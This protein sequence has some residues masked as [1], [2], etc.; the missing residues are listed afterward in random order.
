MSIVVPQLLPYLAVEEVSHFTNTLAVI[1]LLLQLAPKDT[2]PIAESDILPLV[3]KC[4]VG[5]L[6]SALLESVVAFLSSLVTADPPIANRLIPGITSSLEKSPA[7]LASPL[8]ASRCIGAIIRCEM[9]LAAATVSDFA[10]SLKV[11]VVF[12]RFVDTSSRTH[13]FP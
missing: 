8:N 9:G 11:C 3:Y 4:A 2:F 6:P 5:Q 12:R 13:G 1:T 7:A 10:K